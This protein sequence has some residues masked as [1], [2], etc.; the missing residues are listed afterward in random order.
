VRDWVQREVADRF[1]STAKALDIRRTDVPATSA[2]ARSVGEAFADLPRYL[3]LSIS[4]AARRFAGRA[5][6][7][8]N[9]GGER[10]PHLAVAP[11]SKQMPPTAWFICPDFSR[12]SGGI[13]KL[14]RTVDI[15]NG[16]G[17]HAAIVHKR[18]GFRCEWFEHRTRVVNNARTI[19]GH[20]DVI[21]VPEIYGRSICDLPQNIRQVIFNQNVYFLLDSLMREPNLVAPY[22]DNPNLSVVLVV[23]EQNAA[24][25]EYVFPGV[26]VQRVRPGLD[27]ALYYSPITPK[28]RRIA[29]MPRRRAH[30]AAQVLALLRL[31]GI[32][33]GWEVVAIDRRT[34]AEVAD[35]LRTS[36][37]FLSFSEREGFGLPPL[38]AL[39]CGCLVVGYH[40]FGGREFFRQPFATAVED[41][42]IVAF[43]RAVEN[44][45]RLI[46]EDPTKMA[47]V[48]LTGARFV[49][50]HYSP[51]AERKDLLDV[52]VSLLES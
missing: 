4:D 15:L 16:A 14:Y 7:L 3:G 18:P 37:I 46:N 23:S 30:D 44:I 10:V 32:L 19:V 8:R 43:A 29:Y 50:E 27:P 25:I 2:D 28:Y 45:V 17:L 13:R 11:S 6:I 39:A 26:R 12:P 52:F 41:G 21:V 35:L 49:L 1:A 34:E 24:V 31:R 5:G 40:G 38:E 51:D 42:D 47:A 36:Q 22:K 48:G 9:L 33:N 20:R